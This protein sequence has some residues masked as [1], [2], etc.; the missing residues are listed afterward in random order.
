MSKQ[1]CWDALQ[2]FGN[3]K[4]PGNMAYQKSFM[5]VF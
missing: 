1:E 5:S 3:N 2:S 4:S